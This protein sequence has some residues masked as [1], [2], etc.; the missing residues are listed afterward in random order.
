MKRGDILLND[1]A[2]VAMFC[3]NG[4]VVHARSSEGNNLSG[5]QNGAEFR[6]QPYF[7]Y[8]W[9]CV[10]RYAKD[11]EADEP[12]A[13]PEELPQPEFDLVKLN[14]WDR[15]IEHMPDLGY[16]YGLNDPKPEVMAWQAMLNKVLNSGLDVDGEFGALTLAAT[17]EFIGRYVK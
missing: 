1:T 6:I 10:L 7:N 5:D 14:V 11:G 12:E 13:K 2:H 16:G 15:M 8:P 9:N 4:K 17:N 3:G